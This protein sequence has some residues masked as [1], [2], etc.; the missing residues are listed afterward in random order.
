MG[1]VDTTVS[2]RTCQAWTSD[3]PHYNEYEEDSLYPDG[4]VSAAGNKCRNPDDEWNGGVW[5]YTTDPWKEWDTCDVPLCS[6]EGEC[7][8]LLR[9]SNSCS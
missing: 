7:I 9:L 6:Q 5:C 4:S 3:S 8:G 1:D 2:G